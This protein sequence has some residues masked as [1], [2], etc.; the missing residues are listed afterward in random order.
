MVI[1]I[2][3]DV[4]FFFWLTWPLTFFELGDPESV[5]ADNLILSKSV[6]SFIDAHYVKLITRGKCV[7]KKF[8]NA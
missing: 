3:E 2:F 4:A 7:K 5:I 6:T 8:E 1:F